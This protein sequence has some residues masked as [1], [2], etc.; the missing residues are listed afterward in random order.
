MDGAHRPTG[1]RAAAKIVV[2]APLSAKPATAVRIDVLAPT[3]RQIMYVN[4][5]AHFRIAVHGVAVGAV[6]HVRIDGLVSELIR[7]RH[8]PGFL[9]D[10]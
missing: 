10:A 9:V 3:L 2:V 5:Q 8:R 7:L 1:I 4:E 6:V